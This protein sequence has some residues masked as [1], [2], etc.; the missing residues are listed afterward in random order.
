LRL[1]LLDREGAVHAFE[2]ALGLGAG[3]EVRDLLARALALEP[4]LTQTA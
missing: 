1:S 3:G 2:R 4:R